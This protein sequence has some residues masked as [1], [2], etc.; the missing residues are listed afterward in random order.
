VW[1]AAYVAEAY[2]TGAV[3]GVPTA[4]ARDHAFALRHGLFEA[5]AP[6]PVVDTSRRVHGVSCVSFARPYTQYRLRDWLVS[7]QRA[8][9]API[10]VVI[11]D[12][13]GAHTLVAEADLPVLV[14][15][16]LRPTKTK[17]GECGKHTVNVEMNLDV[18]ES[19][20]R[21]FA[22][23]Q[24]LPRRVA[25]PTPLTPSC[26]RAS[27]TYVSRSRRARVTGCPS[28]RTLAAWSTP[29]CTCCTRASWRL[30]SRRRA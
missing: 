23:S 3:M 28:T 4:D 24:A 29:A 10:P 26:A 14:D 15:A 9:G 30:S 21:S 2:G 1:T 27:I 16:P 12:D 19:F 17:C 7:R 22:R 20:S 13:C 25:S 18:Y 8:W 5:G 6:P 11:C